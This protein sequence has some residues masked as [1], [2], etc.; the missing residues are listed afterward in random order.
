MTANDLVTLVMTGSAAALAASAWR[1]VT[2]REQAARPPKREDDPTPPLPPDLAAFADQESEPWAR[3][4]VT[5]ALR[6]TYAEHRTWDAVRA[7]VRY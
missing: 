4:Q 1:Y 5:D 2:L 3:E 7:M 6:E